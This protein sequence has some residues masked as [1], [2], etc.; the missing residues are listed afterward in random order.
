MF[1]C[2]SFD[3]NQPRIEEDISGA[4]PITSHADGSRI[5]AGSVMN[6]RIAITLSIFPIVDSATG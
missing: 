5:V 1:R 4:Q 2:G 3:A 6:C